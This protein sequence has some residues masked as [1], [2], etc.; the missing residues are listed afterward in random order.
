MKSKF[1]WGKLVISDRELNKI[2][3]NKKSLKSVLETTEIDSLL[4][5]AEMVEYDFTQ[6]MSLKD[7]TS[8]EAQQKLRIPQKPLEREEKEKYQ[9]EERKAFNDWKLSMNK[10]LS[11][12]GTITP[13]ERNIQVW[14]QFWFTIEKSD[15]IMQIVDGRNP[16][17]FYTED[18]FKAAPTKKHHL[19]LN[20]A[21]L[22]TEAQKNEWSKYFDSQGIEH[23]FYST[24]SEKDADAFISRWKNKGITIGMIGY[25]NVGKSSTINSLFKRKIV[26]TSIVPGKTKSIQTL[27]LDGLTLCDCPGMVF[28]SFVTLK[29]DL[30]LNGILSLDQTKDIYG[31]LE[32]IVKR[33][34]IR[35]LCYLTKIRS[36]VNDSRR[37]IEENYLTALKQTTGC[38]E[39]GKLIK[40]IIKSYIQGTIKYI[41]APPGIPEDTFNSET[42]PVPETYLLSTEKNYDWYSQETLKKEKKPEISPEQLMYSKKHYLKKGHLTRAFR[43]K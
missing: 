34:G 40:G 26:K 19:L 11:E 38:N 25:P 30:I 3:P 5:T 9:N 37:P 14:R 35:A 10:L 17:L 42:N 12:Q 39:A 33:I 7:L 8:I 28:P 4:E 32:L 21:D 31:C 20:K 41:H 15:V 24:H 2:R 29:Q 22:L 36:F 6:N 18:I 16:L 43:N 1:E 23:T 13:Y 27:D